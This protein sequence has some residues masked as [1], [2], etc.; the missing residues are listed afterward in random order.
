M[1]IKATQNFTLISKLLR[2]MQKNLLT[3]KLFAKKCA[4]SKSLGTYMSI[5]ELVE[6]KFARHGLTNCKTFLNKHF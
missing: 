4:K 6:C 2:K 5:W 3:K 1:G